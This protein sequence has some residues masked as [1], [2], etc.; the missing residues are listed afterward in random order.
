MVRNRLELENLL[1]TLDCGVFYN[2]TTKKDVVNFPYI[3]YLDDGTN[4]FDADNQVYQE[5]MEYVVIVHCLERDEPVIKKLKNLFNEN[6]IPYELN[7][8]D[9]NDQTLFYSVSF[10]I[11]LL[12]TETDPPYSI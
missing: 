8:I 3:V 2:H 9:W 10:I 5:I 6:K 4:N 11:S 12:E 7:G 1:K